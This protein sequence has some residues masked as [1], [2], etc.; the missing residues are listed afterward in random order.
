MWTSILVLRQIPIN[1]LNYGCVEVSPKY[2]FVIL[3]PEKVLKIS[4]SAENFEKSRKF[5]PP[6]AKTLNPRNEKDLDLNPNP[7]KRS[8]LLIT[9][10][11]K[12][13]FFLGI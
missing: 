4:K 6:D 12:H 8:F 7:A 5:R 3:K 11:F 1:Q 9:E 10:N 2:S 13:N